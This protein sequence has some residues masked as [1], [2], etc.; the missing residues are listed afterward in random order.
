VLAYDII[1][2][3]YSVFRRSDAACQQNYF[4]LNIIRDVFYG[5]CRFRRIIAVNPNQFALGTILGRMAES[6]I[7]HILLMLVSESDY[8][9]V[10]RKCYK[11]DKSVKEHLLSP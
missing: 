6:F 10:K 9:P 5:I 8:Y 3:I 11:A 2:E 7:K 1:A 4:I